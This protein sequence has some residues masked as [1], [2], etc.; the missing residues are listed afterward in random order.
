MPDPID[1]Y[2]EK[3]IIYSTEDEKLEFLG[4]ILINPSCRKIYRL[5][6]DNEMSAS[7]IA[8]ET[9]SSLPLV[10]HNL[11][12]LVES[13]VVKITRIKLT[14]RRQRQKHYAAKP[15][16]VITPPPQFKKI[17]TSKVKMANLTKIL[18]SSI[19]LVA[20]VLSWKILQPNT[21]GFVPTTSDS[22]E[23]VSIIIPC[24]LVAIPLVILFLKKK[25]YI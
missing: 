4:K 10:L 1:E 8:K 14:I 19:I 9:G 24:L 21:V 11:E 12:T 18:L 15:H 2:F 23:V 7:E 22:I 20:G 6:I 25:K 16:I 5:L 17:T 3:I 13:G